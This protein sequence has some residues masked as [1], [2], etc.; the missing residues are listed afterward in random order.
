MKRLNV[1]GWAVGCLLLA[2]STAQADAISTSYNW[3]Y[4]FVADGSR[5]NMINNNN[6]L[7]VVLVSPGIDPLFKQTAAGVTSAVST[8]IMAW[9]S[10]T[11]AH[12]Q[13]VSDLPFAINLRLIDRAS[14]VTEYAS[15][16]GTL[17]GNIWDHGSTLSPTFLS[18]LTQTLNIDHRLYTV[19][20]AGFTPPQGA[21]HPGKFVFDVTVR[22]NPEPSALVLA[23]MGMPFFGMVLSRRWRSAVVAS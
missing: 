4:Q 8:P 3:G 6:A 7:G 15:F 13:T 14:D 1:L 10:A 11:M 16:G 18:P 12:P 23:G 22:H 20:F 21:D 17:S 19:S 2:A 5:W 9:S